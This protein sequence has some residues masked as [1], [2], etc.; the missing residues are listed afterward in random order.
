[1]CSICCPQTAQ[2]KADLDGSAI[3]PQRLHFQCPKSN[4]TRTLPG[5]YGQNLA[6]SSPQP[7][8]SSSVICASSKHQ[9]AS[10]RPL[11]KVFSL[12]LFFLP[13]PKSASTP[14]SSSSASSACGA[15]LGSPPY[16]SSLSYR[17]FAPASSM[18]PTSAAVRSP[19][20]SSC[21]QCR[22]AS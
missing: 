21:S 7:T 18:K 13:F 2:Q 12:F 15:L 8:F 20:E 6:E 16:S 22:V 4:A 10:Q 19:S 5:W 11:K 17:T 9:G 14:P 1:M 3:A